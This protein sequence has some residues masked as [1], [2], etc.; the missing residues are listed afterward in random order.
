[1]ME[2]EPGYRK[3]IQEAL[4][5]VAECMSRKEY[6]IPWIR[7]LKERGYRVLYLSNYSGF[8]MNLKPE[9]LDFVPFM[10]GGIFSCHVK[11]IKPEEAIYLKLLDAWS[12][13]PEECV[14]LDD[15]EENIESARRIGLQ[16][17]RFESYPVTKE[18]L[19]RMLDHC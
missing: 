11:L 16:T 19:D 8:V 12:L 4:D 3:E 10:D 17:L 9:V 14:F 15:R 5:H 7:E 1:M 18:K 13:N 6:A 2:R